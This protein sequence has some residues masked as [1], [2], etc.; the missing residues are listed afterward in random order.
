MSQLTFTSTK[1]LPFLPEDCQAN[2][3]AYGFELALWLA[4]ALAQNGIIT[5][6]PVGEDWGWFIEYIEGDAEFMIGCGSHCDQG[7]GYRGEPVAWSVFVKQNLSL[8]QRLKRQANPAIATK[9]TS[10][11]DSALDADGIALEVD[12]SE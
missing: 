3:G 11:I 5:S 9:L 7:E 4:Q 8:V 10:A 6:Y 12:L 1:F 2:P